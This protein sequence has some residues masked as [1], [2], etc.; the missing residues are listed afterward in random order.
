MTAKNR[1]FR[2]DSEKTFA[3]LDL[4]HDRAKG[5]FPQ[6]GSAVNKAR[7]EGKG[8]LIEKLTSPPL[9]NRTPREVSKVSAPPIG[10]HKQP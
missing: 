5:M 8:G 7:K 4:L 2:T 10:K 9:D 3:V 6:R 1:V